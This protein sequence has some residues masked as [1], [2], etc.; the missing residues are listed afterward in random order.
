MGKYT[1]VDDSGTVT[2]VDASGCGDGYYA[3]PEE[4]QC[5][6]CGIENCQASTP[7]DNNIVC[8]KCSPGLVSVD[9]SSCPLTCTELN[10]KEED[11]KCVCAEGFEPS[12]DGACIAKNTCPS[13]ATGCSSCS[14]SGEC[15]S[16]AN[17][18]YNVQPSKRSCAS[19]CPSGSE[20]VGSLCIC[21][22]GYI[23]QDDTCISQTRKTS[24]GS[25]TVTV[26][27]VVSLLIIAAVALT[28]W[29]VL[30]RRRE[31]RAALKKRVIAE[32]MKLMGT[33]DEF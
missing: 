22:E 17:S 27:V 6:T 13:D 32:N 33:V 18:S 29:F 15:L 16:C 2:C 30:R 21:M 24:S 5:A 25:T 28:C 4:L 3:D 20:S 9:G 11:G 10:Q 19:G 23:L 8:T 26:A 1:K 7:K 12:N 31:S 14:A